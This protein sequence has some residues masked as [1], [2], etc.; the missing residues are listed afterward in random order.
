MKLHMNRIQAWGKQRRLHCC[1]CCHSQNWR[2]RMCCQGRTLEGILHARLKQM[3][4]ISGFAKQFAALVSG[5]F[6]LPIQLQP[7][8]LRVKAL[9]QQMWPLLP[10]SGKP[11]QCLQP[12]TS[13]SCKPV[14]CFRR[15]ASGP[16]P[17]HS[18]LCKGRNLISHLKQS[19]AMP[20]SRQVSRLSSAFCS[21]IPSPAASD[22]NI[23]LCNGVTGGR[24]VS[25]ARSGT[26]ERLL[27]C[28]SKLVQWLVSYVMH[29]T[30]IPSV[31]ACRV[32]TQDA[33]GK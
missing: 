28:S 33:L 8:L 26:I 9:Q 14:F 5:T 17:L 27:P 25:L 10:S 6:Q 3:G 23:N 19:C 13:H 15:F 30:P 1:C 32:Q 2:R 11:M 4:D 21:I 18:H 22:A 12:R 20:A 31:M 29:I 24:L 7:H 16:H